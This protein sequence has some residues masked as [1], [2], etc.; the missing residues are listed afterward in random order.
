MLGE[1]FTILAV[2]E[3]TDKI[4]SVIERVDAALDGFTET[5]AK[6]AESATAAGQKIDTSLLQTASGA[7]AVELADARLTE[8][9]NK[10]TQATLAQADAERALLEAQSSLASEGDLAA[11][12]DAVAAAQKRA[13]AAATALATAQ[14]TLE[15][16]EKEALDADLVAAATDRVA[17]AQQEATAATAELTAAQ[18][19]QA[20]LVTSEDAAKAADALTAAEKATA[21]ATTE[22]TAAQDQQAAVQRAAILA[23]E[24]GAAAADEEAAAQARLAASA[25][26]TERGLKLMS[27]G[28]GIAALA[29]AAIGYESVKTAGNFQSLTE[30]LVTDAGESQS[31]L[32]MIR[33]GILNIATA[34]GTSTTDVA[35]GMYHVESAGFHAQAAIDVMT[36]AAEGAKVGGAD[37]DTVSQALTGTMNAFGK[38]G[39][40][41]TQMMNAMIAT[42]AAGDMKMQDLG[43]SLGNVAAVAASAG[44]KY[45]QVGGAIATMTAQNITAQRATQ[46][47]AHTIGSLSNPTSVQVKEMQAMGLNSNT[48]S[49][50]LGS[51]GL[52]GTIK[53][54]TAAIAAHTQGGQ[55]L[56]STYN[57]AAQASANA[58]TM[59]KG[60]SPTLQG[61]AQGL[62]NGTTSYTAYTAA[63][64]NLTP[65]Q[66][67]Q[68]TA[69]EKVADSTK[70][71][72]SLLTSG[73][74]AAQTYNA[75]MA[76]MTG[77]QTSLSTILAI[78]GGHMGTFEKNVASIGAAQSKTSKTVDNWSAI[79]GT[80]NQKLDVAKAAVESAGIMIGTK[81][82]PVISTLVGWVGNL[83]GGLVSW[84]GHNQKLAGLIGSVALGMLAAA[85]GIKAVT[86]A[87]KLWEMAQAGVNAVMAMFDAEAD[88]NPIGLIVIAIAALVAGLIYAYTH[89]KSFRDV[90]NDVFGFLKTF[91]M[92]VLHLVVD[93]FKMLVT[94]TMATW[95]SLETAWGAIAGA[96]QAVWG[97]V[98][99][100]WDAVASTT[101]AIWN[102]IVG[103]FSK[104][105]QDILSALTK[106]WDA[107]T[108]VTSAAWN[109]ITAF[110]KKWW[111]LLFVIFTGPIAVLDALWN[112]FGDAILS[113]A[114]A[115]WNAIA[116]FFVTIWDAITSAAQVAW[117]AIASF[118]AGLWHGIS[119]VATAAWDGITAVLGAAWSG[120]KSVA[121]AVWADV[122]LSIIDPVEIV[123]SYLQTVAHSMMSLLESA[124]RSIES[125]ASSIWHAIESAIVSPLES[126]WHTVTS[127]V[128]SIASSIWSGLMSAWHAV[129]NIGSWFLS[130][131][132]DIVNGIISGVENAG[133]ALMNTL[134]NLASDALDAAKS[135]LGIGS[136]SKLFRDEVGQWIPH[137]IADGVTRYASVAQKAVSDL[138]DSLTGTAHTAVTGSLSLAGSGLTA[139]G[140]GSGAGG[141]GVN[142]TLD[143]RGAVVANAAAMNQLADTVGKAVVKKLA[144]A[145]VHIRA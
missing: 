97:A 71:F 72:N 23:T 94:A 119:A 18:E 121:S 40:T 67:S 26:S 123:W 16:Y 13:T 50:N 137:G 111:P 73:S 12:T 66:Y 90:V 103:F 19:R 138:S 109:A 48:V 25:A 87:T 36:V 45:D 84:I 79:Q 104:V 114:Q 124:W 37:L 78:S 5:A 82:L 126:A 52:T 14:E 62:L 38:S 24:E 3:A 27:A 21:K 143:L 7:D 35:N 63:I 53:T 69:F 115:T 122:K 127:V 55:V 30:H 58:N 4:S 139:V 142:L 31:K 64:K 28:G 54:L 51:E 113:A 47:L 57:N 118:F 144:P 128:S 70:Q 102:S 43:S 107:V 116:G 75:A 49:K 15:V 120:I 91:A 132:S 65:I 83:L 89:F 98:V 22:A 34:T 32:A 11:A 110:F 61:L 33:T 6:A 145:G 29:I 112:H 81:L 60:M 140:S 46:D 85:A 130:I 105:G 1:A 125:V 141:G 92:T 129:E 20:A 86:L 95:H 44:L 101:S 133:A 17:V 135:F 74:P 99:A 131:G 9:Q 108:R 10:L 77:G 93:G 56:I 88:A 106:A 8:A 117:N 68:M 42:V 59:M 136:P 76:K 39:G 96:A 100:A 134:G 41:A 80:M 2:L